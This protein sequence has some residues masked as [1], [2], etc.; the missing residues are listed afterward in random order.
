ML[1]LPVSKVWGVGN[2]LVERTVRELNGD[3]W[4]EL[5][6]MQPETKQVMS[7]R[8]FGSRVDNLVDLEEAISYHSTMACTRMWKKGMY[9]QMVYVFI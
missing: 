2:Q 7:S 3:S 5:D 1:A 4:L 8:S 6:E 9:A